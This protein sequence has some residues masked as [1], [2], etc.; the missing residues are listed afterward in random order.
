MFLESALGAGG[1]KGRRS[2]ITDGA[3]RGR[4]PRKYRDQLCANVGEVVELV[5]ELL[6][7]QS[8]RA[9]GE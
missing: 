5:V 3:G 7:F 1:L 8:W 6:R 4:V 2:Q 9:E